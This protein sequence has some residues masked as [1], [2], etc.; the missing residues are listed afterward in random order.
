MILLS[1]E[2]IKT[3]IV[4]NVNIIIEDVGL[5]L[6]RFISSRGHVFS[7]LMHSASLL[8]QMEHLEHDTKGLEVS[9]LP[10]SVTKSPIV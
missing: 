1:E 4:Q 5:I 2:N 6:M 9:V 8:Q 3:I 10:Q 7:I